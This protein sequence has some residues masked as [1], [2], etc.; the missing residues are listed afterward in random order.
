[1]KKLV[2]IRH[3]EAEQNLKNIADFDRP[4]TQLGKQDAIQ[5]AAFLR[6]KGS[7]PQ[8]V[9]SSPALRALTTAHIFTVTLGLNDAETDAKI[10]EADA[11]ALLQ[12]VDQMDEQ[13]EVIALVGHN[14]G[15]SNLLY[16]LTGEVTTM[17]PCAW[18]EIVL[19]AD[20][21]PEVSGNTGKLVQYQYP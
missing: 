2:L 4:L 12:V 5:M 10:Y 13:H 11:N 16:L 3:A 1:M 20:L 15:I 14:P 6:K 19:E 17:P 8:H 21:W 18:A 7:L 9:I